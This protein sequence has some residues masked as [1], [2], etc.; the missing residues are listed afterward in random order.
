MGN[1]NFHFL[2]FGLIILS[3]SIFSCATK[4]QRN[5]TKY[6]F[7]LHGRIIEIQGK[8][9]VSEEFGRYEF[10]SIVNALKIPNSIVIAEVRMEN[11][12]Y[13]NYVKK[14]SNQVDSLI[15]N[16][17]KPNH[18]T[19]IGASKGAI[20]ASMVSDI[21]KNP[22]NYILLAGNNEYQ[23]EHNDWHF[24]G[25]VL[26]IYDPSDSLAGKNY[27]YWKERSTEL[28]SFKEIELNLGYGHGFL[29]KPYSEWI[30]P[31]LDWIEI[32]SAK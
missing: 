30:E 8:N 16:G 1:N 11:V 23:E 27:Q 14:I 31:S 20:M 6:I 15:L 25:N 26:A 4:A 22:I 5:D 9:A 10:D 17:I 28:Q 3:L 24:H 12:D 7:Y 13:S 2:A 29:Y 18:I 19:V 32:N 21:N